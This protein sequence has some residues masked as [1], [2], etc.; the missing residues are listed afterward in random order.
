MPDN[1]VTN[2]S[3]ATQEEQKEWPK[4]KYSEKEQLY[5]K[6]VVN[7]IMEA[8]DYRDQKHDEFD[9]QTYLQYCESN[10]KGANTYV[11]PKTNKSDN[12]YTSGTIRQK[13]LTYLAAIN[14]LNLSPDIQAFDEEER[15]QVDLGEALEDI[16]FKVGELDGEGGDEEKKLLRQYRMFEQGTVFVKELFA[17]KYKPR[18]KL[19]GEFDGKLDS[20]TWTTILEKVYEGPTRRILQNENVILGNYRTFDMADQPFVV[21]IEIMPW[22]EAETKYRKFERWKFVP[23]ELTDILN[24]SYL[25]TKAYNQFKLYAGSKNDVEIVR[26]CDSN[27]NEM[28]IWIN[29]VMMLPIGFPMLTDGYDI[30]KQVNEVIS[31]NFALGKSMPARLKNNTLLLDEML[32]LA[33]KKTQK[34]FAP[35]LAN[36]TGKI[37]NSRVFSPGRITTG[38]NPE[39][40]GLIDPSATPVQMG[41]YQMIKGL[42]DNI[43]KN[44]VTATFAG[45]NPAGTVTATQI[46]EVQRQAKM[47]MGL[48]EMTCALLEKKL[49]WLRINNILDN[50][51]K[52]TGRFWDEDKQDFINRYRT[53][54]REKHIEG[55]G[56]GQSIVRV[57]EDVPSAEQQ[58]AEENEL[59]EFDAETGKEIKPVRITYIDPKILKAAKIIWY[60][61]VVAK[62]KKSDALNKVLF[63]EMAGQAMQFPHINIE[64]LEERFAEK[65]EENPA[66]L[67]GASEPP[68]EE[69]GAGAAATQQGPSAGVPQPPTAKNRSKILDFASR[70]A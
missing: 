7:R 16:I 12:K 26:Y 13:L 18:K 30:A 4:P 29:G 23:K 21:D 32:R 59:S 46:L 57:T 52:P 53:V 42:Q 62:E 44:S 1:I 3:P 28:M 5:Y 2:S 25:E 9:G 67:F 33:L 6:R 11:A 27:A 61:V 35:P 8:R 66:K 55:V 34:S 70:T 49:A 56:T 17:K 39:K 19:E 60:I 14:M 58:L 69:A 24:N 22:V 43:D 10:K 48:T 45:Q 54:S 51:F 37:L 63:N 31:S 41:E 64:Y 15:E 38:I 47:M 40:I 20:A 36:N 50:W 68:P 65:W